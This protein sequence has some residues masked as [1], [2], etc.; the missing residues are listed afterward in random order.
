MRRAGPSHPNATGQPIRPDA[1]GYRSTM[2]FTGD[3]RFKANGAELRLRVLDF[4]RWSGSDLVSNAQRGVLAEYIVAQAVGDTREIRLEWDSYDVV[5]HSGT[6]IE[7]K[8]AAYLQAW[9]QARP[10]TIR[11]SIAPTLG[12]N[13][14]TNVYALERMRSADVYVFALLH[15]SDIATLNPLD[16]DQWTFF[17]LGTAKLPSQKTIGLPSLLRLNPIKTAFDGLAVAI[18][19]VSNNECGKWR[20]QAYS[21][22]GVWVA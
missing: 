14:E 4:W 2:R 12:W 3:E 5:S 9:A 16:L 7:V 18:E 1:Q 10:S 13:A 15:H 22:G 21:C 20:R 17:V 19:A 6:K 8:S 11:F